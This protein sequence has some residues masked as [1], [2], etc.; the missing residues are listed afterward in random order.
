MH[1]ADIRHNTDVRRGDGSERRDLS[2][3]AHTDLHNGGT[4]LRRDAEQRERQSDLVVVVRCSAADRAAP[5]EHG[6]GQ[7]L[8]CR[9]AVRTRDCNNGNIEL[10]APRVRDCLIRR[11]CVRHREDSALRL[12]K[13]L[14]YGVR[15]RLCDEHRRCPLVERICC[16]IRAIKVLAAQRDKEV[17]I[18]NLPRV[19]CDMRNGGIPHKFPTVHMRAC[20]RAQLVPCQ[21]HVTALQLLRAPSRGRRNEWFRPSESGSSHAPCRE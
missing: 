15:N 13:S 18:R 19:G 1:L 8:R 7:I 9:L 16:K 4:I 6:G 12:F 20:R 2:H 10:Y 11:K 14:L 5:R 21:P 17:S 3:A